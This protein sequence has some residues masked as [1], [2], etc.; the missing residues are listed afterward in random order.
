MSTALP[1]ALAGMHTRGTNLHRVDS[2]RLFPFTAVSDGLVLIAE[3]KALVKTIR[4]LTQRLTYPFVDVCAT[5]VQQL[6]QKEEVATGGQK[7]L[8]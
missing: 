8:L 2:I 4:M 6:H 1:S 3:G 5:D 7:L